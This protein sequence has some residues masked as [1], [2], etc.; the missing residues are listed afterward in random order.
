MDN[1]GSLKELLDF[2]DMYYYNKD[3]ALVSDAEYDSIK[4]IYLKQEN[5]KDYERVSGYTTSEER[6]KHDY[7]VLSLTEFQ[8][9][10]LDDIREES[11]K[12]D[13]ILMVEP[14]YDG[15]S[16]VIANG[17]VATRG[18]GEY[19]EDVT[20]NALSIKGIDKLLESGLHIRGEALILKEDFEELNKK[21]IE[22]GEE[23]YK[24]SRNTVSGMIRRKHSNPEKIKLYI[25]E[26]LNLDISQTEK[27]TILESLSS[28]DVI[29]TSAIS[30]RNKEQLE[31]FLS[32][33]GRDELDNFPFDVDGLVVK[34]DIRNSLKIFGS[35]NHHPKN[36]FAIK[37]PVEGK[38]TK[39]LGITH[40]V[41][42]TGKIVPVAEL[43]PVDI[44]GS[45][46]SR[47]TLH[48]E[49]FVK[50]LNLDTVLEG[51]KVKVIKANE[52][53][54][55]II[56]T[57][58]NELGSPIGSGIISRCPI[59]GSELVFRNELQYCENVD[60]GAKA[61]LRLV[62][63]SKR[64]CLD[65]N[66]LSVATVD[67]MFDSNLIENALDIFNLKIEDIMK[68]EGFGEKSATNLY[69]AINDKIENG[70]SMA[71]F[72]TSLC[73]PELGKG[74]AK[75]IAK[76]IRTY[77]DLID[78]IDNGLKTIKSISGIGP[79][80]LENLINNKN[81]II[82]LNKY[83]DIIKEED[84]EETLTK[85]K[86]CISGKFDISKKEIEKILREKGYETISSVTKDCDILLSASDT[87]SKYKEAIKKNIRIEN[88][89]NNI[90]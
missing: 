89:Y 46:V 14:K 51:T 88:D 31:E 66:G 42:R 27:L 53:I 9:D 37:F 3:E 58:V 71:N 48:N 74:T 33:L 55:A 68:L 5:L 82:N 13:N 38:W 15:I 41:G 49:Q 52:I 73:I 76:E 63:M 39:I 20:K 22:E 17:K 77:E 12:L 84:I 21:R 65:I 24:N 40:Q 72:L 80:L 34:S 28:E 83:I 54:P 60:C 69:N 85:G 29:T 32:S 7:P 1:R 59:C 18:D 81:S 26:I 30:I 44:L 11:E 6:I 64:E 45:T 50:A 75:V 56:E 8:A 86:V 35:T 87:S 43:E 61:K 57:D 36:A 25:Y 47:A 79:V 62:H 90:K 78:D 4:N 23:P 16:L 67:K 19:G 70:I 10:K 2:Y